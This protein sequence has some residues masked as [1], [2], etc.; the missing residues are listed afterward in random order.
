MATV[1][2]PNPHLDHL[3][4]QAKDLLRS[5]Q[6]GDPQICASAQQYLPRFSRLSPDG[7]TLHDAQHVIARQ[8]G[9]DNW[10]ALRQSV[11][12]MELLEKLA[13]L[14]PPPRFHLL[15]YPGVLA[16]RARDRG[17]IVPA[18]PVEESTAPGVRRG[19]PSTLPQAPN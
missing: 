11:K 2:P 5:F 6:S 4:K 15:R 12:L 3:K 10:P 16:P 14:V 18:K 17:R 13:A 7:F 1:L 9:F 8:Y 19:V